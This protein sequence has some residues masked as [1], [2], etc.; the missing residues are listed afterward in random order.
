MDDVAEKFEDGKEEVAEAYGKVK[1]K[2][3]EFSKDGQAV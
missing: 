2:A 3:A 1:T